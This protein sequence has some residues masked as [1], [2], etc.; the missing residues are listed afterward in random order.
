MT[1]QSTPSHSPGTSGPGTSGP[2]SSGP[3]A[4]AGLSAPQPAPHHSASPGPSTPPVYDVVVIGGGAAGLSAAVVL[5]RAR[6]SVIVVDGGEPRNAPAA[7]VHSYLTRD[8]VSPADFVRHGQD[9]ARSYGALL[10]A[11]RAVDTRRSPDGFTVSL[12]DGRSVTG[13]RLLVATGLVDELP[14]LPGLAA[15]WGRDVLHCPYCHGW[16]VRDQSIGILGTGPMSAHQA[17]LFRQWSS[18]VTLFLQGD[19][20]DADGAPSDEHGP[21]P[22]EWEKLAARGVGVVIGP[23]E[24]LEVRDDALVGVRLASGRLM[25]LDAL[26]VAPTFTARTGFLAGLGVA[27]IPHA[28]GVGEHLDTDDTGRVLTGG[29]VVPG[30][31]AAGNAANLMAQVVVSA[32]AGL[33][34]ATVI[35]ADLISAEIETAVAA[36]RNPFSAAAEA[37]NSLRVLGDRRHGLA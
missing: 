2:D 9:E 15:R 3:D 14:D 29:T 7:G 30:V 6:R 16:E 33:S 19:L 22:D 18:D 23:V 24:S 28:M 31:W 27:A 10:L 34:V 12:D 20:L 8:G 11:G 13:R 5:G 25:P 17:L 32:A 4:G 21:T 26:V 37:R 1:S 35:N 36:Y